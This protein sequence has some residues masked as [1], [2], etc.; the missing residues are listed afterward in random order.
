[1]AATRPSIIS[2][3]ATMSAPALARLAAVRAIVLCGY[4][5]I[6][7]LLVAAMAPPDT[8]HV[9]A[10]IKAPDRLFC[11]RCGEPK[12]KKYCSGCGV[13]TEKAYR[14]L[15]RQLGYYAVQDTKQ[16][17]LFLETSLKAH[18]EGVVQAQQREITTALD[19]LERNYV[20]EL[21]RQRKALRVNQLSLMPPPS[22]EAEPNAENRGIESCTF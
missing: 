4:L 8:P 18:L 5:I 21:V 14:K 22:P 1:M 10:I 16:Q 7:C 2:L 6:V 3:G 13:N 9:V 19:T 15:V 12:T 17:R 11:P 20:M